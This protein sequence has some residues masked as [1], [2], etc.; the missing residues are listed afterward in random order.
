MDKSGVRTAIQAGHE[1]ARGIIARQAVALGFLPPA[2]FALSPDDEDAAGLLLSMPYRLYE[3]FPIGHGIVDA[4]YLASHAAWQAAHVLCRALEALGIAAEPMRDVSLKVTA[5]EAGVGRF[6]HNQLVCHETHGS[7]IALQAVRVVGVPLPDG[8]RK[9]TRQEAALPGCD[10][11][12]RC[13]RACPTGALRDGGFDAGRCLRTWMLA[14]QPVPETMREAMGRRLLGCEEC[15]RACPHTPKER[16]APPSALVVA[17][18]LQSLC[19]AEQ[20]K[21]LMPYFA[22]IVGANNARESRWAQQA[23]VCADNAR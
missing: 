22:Q 20:R 7:L 4:Y 14:G 9:R 13:Q 2:W 5:L 16:V 17:C 15:R 19:N 12:G 18:N 11:C 10:A 6:G 3:D 1:E 21:A 23:A 8:L